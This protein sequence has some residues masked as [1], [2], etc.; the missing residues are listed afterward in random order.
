MRGKA[1]ARWIAYGV[2]CALWL[3]SAAA[4]R[5]DARGAPATIDAD[6]LSFE[7]GNNIARGEGNVVVRYRDVVICAD[8]AWLN[9][10]TQ[11]AWAEGNVCIS[12]P[13][14][15]WVMP[16]AYYNFGDDAFRAPEVRGQFD[17]AYVR[18]T[19]IAPAGTNL[20]RTARA[21][22][23]TCDYDQPHY[24]VEATHTKIWPGDRVVL[25]NVTFRLGNVPVFWL[26]VLV[27]PLSGEQSPFTIRLGHTSE[28]GA[29]VLTGTRWRLT[30]RITATAHL[31][32]RSERG[33]G[34]GPDLEYRS[35]TAE[36]LLRGYYLHDQQPVEPEDAGKG[37]DADRWRVQW[38]HKQAVYPDLS[39]TVQLN[40][41]S[42]PDVLDDFF[43]REFRMDR[44]PQSVADLTHRGENHTLSLLVR[45]QL[46][47]YFAEVERLPEVKWVMPRTRLWRTPLFYAGESSA[48]Y[49]SN[50]RG[51][52][53]DA[54]FSGATMRLDTFHQVLIPHTLA[55]WLSVVPRAAIRYSYYD[56]AP[57]TAADTSE[58]RRVVYDLGVETSLK[59]SRTWPDARC[60]WLQINGLRH[61][62][63]PYAN[64]L[65]IPEPNVPAAELFQFDSPRFVTLA[66]GE[67]LLVSRYEPLDFP[68]R[69]TSDRIDREHV[70]RFGLAQRLQTR[71]A[72]QPW[73]LVEVDGW[74]DYRIQHEPGEDDFSDFFGRLQLRP[75]RWL[76]LSADTRLNLP[77]GELRELNTAVALRGADRW[78]L[79]IGT[80]F[81]QDD[82]HLVAAHWVCRLWR[83]WTIQAAQRYDFEDDFWEEQSVALQQ[84]THDWL[85]TY[86]VRRKGNR[87]GAD[88]WRVVVAVTLKAYPQF[89][90]GT[91]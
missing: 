88:D 91:E 21:T 79:R 22:V 5:A 30:E 55:G 51:Q 68:A 81:L 84:E 4:A 66:N 23:T 12:R 6:K 47:D 29:Y 1:I 2:V 39:L 26:P 10:Q 69:T 54:T 20:Y 80:R 33:F 85:I 16:S 64:Y 45:P 14:N 65:W 25:Y 83:G 52:T 67:R 78:A 15:H 19:D 56:D 46:N 48:G 28:W 61:I 62:V 37:I 82:S 24:R 43:P 3:A 31:D 87:E 60:R 42:D 32:Y 50:H 77:E 53:G 75:A 36:S 35:R 7:Q 70:V 71:R 89:H 9:L 34:F 27:W 11:E 41:L 63:Q 90:L 86:G 49:Y 18:A 74:T 40:K 73:D 57:L 13:G 8:R 58:V 76:T 38:Q 59:L 44:E 17:K 72:G